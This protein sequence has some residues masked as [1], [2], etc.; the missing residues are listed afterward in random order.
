MREP[1]YGKLMDG[2]GQSGQADETFIG[3]TT[4]RAG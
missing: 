2:R 1:Y 3:R 4:T